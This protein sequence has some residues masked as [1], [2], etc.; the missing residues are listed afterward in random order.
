MFTSFSSSTATSSYKSLLSDKWE[1]DRRATTQECVQWQNILPNSFPVCLQQHMGSSC[2]VP[3]T[4]LLILWL[5][6]NKDFSQICQC[7]VCKLLAIPQV[8]LLSLFSRIKTMRNVQ[9]V[10]LNINEIQRTLF[11][12][13]ILTFFCNSKCSLERKKNQDFCWMLIRELYSG[14]SKQSLCVW[15]GW[16]PAAF[17]RN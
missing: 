17:S 10:I 13:Q 11:W 9:T 5:A 7:R 12:N 2:I 15:I 6:W 16:L 8:R 4:T 1:G 14:F 3:L